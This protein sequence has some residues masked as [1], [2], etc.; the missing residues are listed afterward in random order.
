VP[1]TNP[2]PNHQKNN[3]RSKALEE[4]AQRNF[5][6]ASQWG[7]GHVFYVNKKPYLSIFVYLFIFIFSFN[8]E[9]KSDTS[10]LKR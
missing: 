5:D 3:K 1:T 6:L 9:H 4:Q 8:F 10:C 2:Q 7:G